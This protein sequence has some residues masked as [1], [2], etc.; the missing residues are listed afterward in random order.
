ME[1]KRTTE[2]SLSV[3]ISIDKGKD[4]PDVYDKRDGFNFK[5]VNFP[6][7]CSNIP[8][9]PA[10]EMYIS[11]LS[12]ICSTYLWFLKLRLKGFISVTC[13]SNYHITVISKRANHWSTITYRIGNYIYLNE[14]YSGATW[15]PQIL[16][17]MLYHN[18]GLYSV[19]DCSFQL[20]PSILAVLQH[21]RP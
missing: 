5:I 2:T 6:Q 18:S 16:G 17:M 13:T 10:Y 12:R 8:S 11:K 3:L 19:H 4:F 9:K 21:T 7:M 14:P 15:N 1:L 20:W